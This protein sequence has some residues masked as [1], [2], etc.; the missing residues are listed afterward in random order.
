[1]N[2]ISTAK[3]MQLN[4]FNENLSAYKA[5]RSSGVATVSVNPSNKSVGAA[6]VSV[7]PA[8]QTP[9]GPM[10]VERRIKS[11]S[12]QGETDMQKAKRKRLSSKC[13]KSKHT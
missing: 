2:R 12:S 6:T 5:N 9:Q 13:Q 4:S 8:R 11:D 3:G 1:M 10:P 7:N